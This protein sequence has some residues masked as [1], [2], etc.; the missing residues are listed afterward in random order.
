MVHKNQKKAPF[1]F[2]II[3]LLIPIFIFSCLEI[4]LRLFDYGIDTSTWIKVNNTH[5]ELNPN[6]ARRYFTST[7]TLPESIKDIFEI[8]K[9]KST[10]RVFVLG[11]SSAAGYPYM[12]LGA[13][14]RYIQQRFKHN[15]PE[16]KIEV[17]NLGLSA[18]N[19]FTIS[20]L[21]PDVIDQNPDLILIYFG[22]NEYYG[23]LGVGSLESFGDSKFLTNMIIRFNKFRLTQFL[24]DS[25]VAL[26]SLFSENNSHQAGTLMS[27]MAKEKAIPF[28]SNIYKRGLTQFQNNFSDILNKITSKNIHVI[29]ST[30]SS[31]VKDQPPFISGSNSVN[32]NLFF[33]RAETEKGKMNYRIAD[34]LFRLAKDYDQLRFRA[35]SEI[36]NI[37]INLC[38]SFNV[39]IVQTDS[40]ISSISTHGLIGNNIMIDHLHFSLEGYQKV[41][42]IFYDKMIKLN[43]LPNLQPKFEQAIQDSITK[44][45]YIYTELD[46]T[47][48]DY[49]ISLLK[50]D[51]PFILRDNKK[52]A[53]DLL[54]QNN[55]V[56]SIAYKFV[57]DQLEW[58]KAHRLLADYFLRNDEFDKCKKHFDLLIYQYPLVKEYNTFLS[59][60]LIKRKRF[61]EAIEYLQRGNNIEPNAYFTKWLGI[62]YLSNRDIDNAINNLESSLSFNDK[63]TQVLYNL[64]GAYSNKKE[65]NKALEMLNKCLSLK[66][67]Y[68]AAKK[69][70]I[71]LEK[72][73]SK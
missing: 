11:G 10:Y 46:S 37:I 47:I 3:L 54:I 14:S 23:A 41:G 18:V 13:F 67:N 51:W 57:T 63:D 16:K 12:P 71:Q 52:H 55:F 39:P 72:V 42:E 24:R 36:N 48:S 17:V 32:A 27:R 43:Y 25:I 33:S 40:I 49:K 6:V 19:S 26:S 30:I 69:L 22:H 20:D 4:C 35:P 7:K 8:E 15:Y 62:I 9:S 29:V 59:E 28:N 50:N 56:D 44:I 21:L 73:V 61:N 34:S 38:D 53:S 68:T 31:N 2:Y 65:Y 5:L 1:Y 70:K 60:Q 64:S 45:N 66:P 58:E